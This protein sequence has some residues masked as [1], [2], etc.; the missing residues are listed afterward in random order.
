MGY[1]VEAM[2]DLFEPLVDLGELPPE[3][4]Y[5][6]LVFA[7]G[8]GAMTIPRGSATQVCFSDHSCTTVEN[9]V[10]RFASKT[11]ADRIFTKN[12]VL[13]GL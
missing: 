9:P 11:D 10:L 8:H 12:Q 13:I 4:F 1:E 6:L 3:K 5:Q 2:V 7:R